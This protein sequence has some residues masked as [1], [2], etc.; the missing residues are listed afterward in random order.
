MNDSLSLAE[1]TLLL[2][3]FPHENPPGDFCRVDRSVYNILDQYV[4]DSRI[5]NIRDSQYTK[6]T[7]AC[8]KYTSTKNFYVE[9][10]NFK[11]L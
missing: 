9:G 11:Y 4:L 5:H 1:R 3:G 2:Q 10:P 7:G 6:P 8:L